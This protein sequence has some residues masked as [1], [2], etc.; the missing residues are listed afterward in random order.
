[1][2]KSKIFLCVTTNSNELDNIREMVSVAPYF[3]GMLVAYHGEKNETWDLLQQHKGEGEVVFSDYFNHHGHAKN[4]WLMHPKCV[5]DFTWCFLRDSAERI[6]DNFAK[7]IHNFVRNLESQNISFVTQY[8]KMLL[9]K[10]RHFQ[11]FHS[12]PHWGLGGISGNGIQ[13]EKYF[14]ESDSAY[15]VRN[16]RPEDNWI[17]H[18]LRYYLSNDSNHLLLGREN[19]QEEFHKLEKQRQGFLVMCRAKYNIIPNVDNLISYWKDNINK[20]DETDRFYINNE[21]ILNDAYHYLVLGME[22]KTLKANHDN[23]ICIDV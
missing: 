16:K 20:L 14:S 6:N 18:A 23:G 4:L 15:S 19:K 10:R 8:S 17:K 5:P 1:M 22:Y 3:D 11:Y 12:H 2:T 21:L 7:N 13:I 9:F